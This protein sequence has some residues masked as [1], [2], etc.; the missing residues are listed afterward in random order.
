MKCPYLIIF[1]GGLI[2]FNLFT[3]VFLKQTYLYIYEKQRLP[4]Y[5][6]VNL[7]VNTMKP[8]LKVIIKLIGMKI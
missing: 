1:T 3:R 6:T 8:D 5:N 7:I 4:Q 2:E